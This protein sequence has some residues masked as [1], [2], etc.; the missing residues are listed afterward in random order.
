MKIALLSVHSCPLQKLG[1]EDTGGMSVYIRE[2]ARE[3]G[4]RG[5]QV[6]IY[7]RAHDPRDQQVYYLDT[8]VRLIHIE[9]GR[10]E[11]IN[12]LAIFPHARDLAR[13]LNRFKRQNNIEYDVIHSHYWL[14]GL[15]GLWLH[16]WWNIP[17][18][19]MFHTLGAVKNT[20][21]IGELEPELRI[22]SERDVAA[23]CDRVIAATK[24]ERND[25][26]N[27]Y[28][29]SADNIA[30]IPCGINLDLFSPVDMQL[31]RQRLGMNGHKVILY[32]GRINPLKG[33]DSL[34]EAVNHMNDADVRL[35]V[36][37]G[38]HEQNHSDKL[39][40]YAGQIDHSELP[41]YYSAA[42]VCVIP[43]H[44]ETFCLVALESLACGTPLVA[45]DVGG[46]GSLIKQGENGHILEDNDPERM[47]HAVKT[48]LAGK[49]PKNA[50]RDAVLKYD[51][52]NIVDVMIAQYRSVSSK[53]LN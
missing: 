5:H 16:Q 38:D 6:D 24:R 10:V 42:D 37:G 22:T 26:I 21:G 52:S 18:V 47:A 41:Y 29:A 51:W 28:G 20:V 25:L 49:Y 1:G 33:L 27:Y 3:L 11:E 13:N 15:V 39:V 7:T 32:V 23:G 53:S 30:V 31:A 45:T 19:T 34:I 43:S 35:V 36:V 17:H 14:S 2:L 8:N 50:A 40:D 4:S 44:Y 9:A 48:V 12:K 46:I